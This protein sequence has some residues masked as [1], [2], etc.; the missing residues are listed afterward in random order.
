[1]T[2][3]ETTTY[4]LGQLALPPT[5]LIALALAGVA[6][7][8]WRR[9][10]GT[11]IAAASLLA[12]LLLSTT[13]AARALVQTLE[14]PALAPGAAAGAQ[15]IV[16]LAG[17]HVR[18]SAEWG[19]DTV[20]AATLRR[21]RYG[22]R[23]ARETGLPVLLSGGDPERT[24]TPEARLMQIAFERDFGLRPRWVEDRSETTADNARLTAKLL[25]AAGIRRVL[26]VTDAVHMPRAHR[27]F[28]RAGLDAV[29]APTGYVGSAPFRWQHLVPNA[30]ALRLSNVALREWT[31]RLW[32]WLRH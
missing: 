25:A 13:V 5:S 24:G 32:Y 12:L 3:G 22:A 10:A 30:E 28:A 23:L 2:A 21:L 15:A 9:R 29:A 20:N 18:G 16:I 19:A 17:G 4:V 31:A 14:S 1:M 7:A 11:A 27:A 6:I 26:L 8:R